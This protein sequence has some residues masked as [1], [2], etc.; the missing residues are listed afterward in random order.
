MKKVTDECIIDDEGNH[1]LCERPEGS[2]RID[3]DN[4]RKEV[5]VLA[6]DLDKVDITREMQML[7]ER[8]MKN[9]PY[10]EYKVNRVLQ[11]MQ[12]KG[13]V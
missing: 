10:H 12:E 2:A 11:M 1:I 7:E 8:Y 6:V 3:F 13:F 5:S 9:D 4:P